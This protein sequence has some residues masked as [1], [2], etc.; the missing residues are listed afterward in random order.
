[1]EV[2][3]GAGPLGLLPPVGAA[4]AVAAA[5]AAPPVPAVDEMVVKLMQ[6][7]GGVGNCEYS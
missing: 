2:G 5:V 6:I 1:M 3:A 7:N 4:A